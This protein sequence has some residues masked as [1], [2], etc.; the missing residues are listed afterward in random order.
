MAVKACA[1]AAPHIECRNVGHGYVGLRAARAH[2]RIES[3]RLPACP[4]RGARCCTPIGPLLPFA[5][6]PT[7]EASWSLSAQRPV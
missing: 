7:V 6:P 1:Y 4:V 3:H 5:G 2:V